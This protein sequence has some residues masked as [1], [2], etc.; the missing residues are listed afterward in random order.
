M[1]EKEKIFEPYHLKGFFK[2]YLLSDTVDGAKYWWCLDSLEKRET[3]NSISK[4][5]KLGVLR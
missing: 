2:L 1:K 4:N 5:G 3:N